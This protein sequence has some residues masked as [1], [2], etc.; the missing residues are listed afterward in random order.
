MKRKLQMKPQ[1]RS[2]TISREAIDEEARTVELSFSSE[3]PVER[4]FGVEIL[5]HKKKSVRLDRFKSGAANLLMDHDRTD[6]VGVIEDVKL[7]S[8]PRRGT[9]TARFGNSARASE[10][11][12]D[13]LDGI[14]KSVSVTY[15]IFEAITEKVQKNGPE[16]V[17]ITDWEPLEVSLVSIPADASVGIARSE[18][19]GENELIITREISDMN[20]CIVCKRDVGADG[21]PSVNDRGHCPE[22]AETIK[23][24]AARTVTPPEPQPQPKKVDVEAEKRKAVEDETVRAREIYAQADEYPTMEGVR[25][26][27]MK[28]VKDGGTVDQM[29]Q[30]ILSKIGKPGSLTLGD[31]GLSDKEQR[32]YSIRAAMAA[33]CGLI[34]KGYEHEVSKALGAEMAKRG[35][36]ES[37]PRGIYIPS[38]LGMSVAQRDQNKGTDSAGGYLVGTDHRGDLFIE[39]L[40]KKALLMLMGARA[41]TG[42]V[43][44][45][46]IPKQTGGATFYWITEGNDTTESQNVYSQV[47]MTPKTGSAR[48]D[49]TRKLLLQSDPSIDALVRDDLLRGWAIEMDRVGINGAS[50]SNE[51]VGILNTTGIGSV[52]GGTDGAAM[53]WGNVVDLE[54]EVAADDADLGTLGYLLNAKVRGDLKQTEK[55]AGSGKEIM[56]EGRD[57]NGFS[58]LN[59]YRAGI[60]NNVP[61]NL[62]KGTGTNLSA[63]IFGNFNDMIYGFWGALDMMNDPITNADSGGLVIRLFQDLDIAIRHAES[64]SAMEDIITTI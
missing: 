49:M 63:A 19:L 8:D 12:Q 29:R 9:V 44:D 33:E 55:F 15:R 10:V 23:V 26:E 7:V 30:F 45:I 41:L 2:F 31:A 16:I 21:V 24:E 20:K 28:L 52:V 39:I 36:G 58:S 34:N 60:S 48:V 22:C 42:L 38:D 3:T 6:V 47:T 32:Q 1:S 17:R 51:P 54:S 59:G 18:G 46:A 4:F 13:V 27:A 5:D 53:T 64:F 25:D 35:L 61:S 43:G 62:T 57:A 40:R 56:G 11:F 50:A 14:R 37:S